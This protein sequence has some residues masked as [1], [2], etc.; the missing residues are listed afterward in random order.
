MAFEKMRTRPKFMR[1][2]NEPPLGAERS[3]QN[4]TLLSKYESIKFFVRKR[5]KK[6]GLQVSTG[7]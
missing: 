6:L 7:G 3:E 2:E 4:G 5:K 1:T